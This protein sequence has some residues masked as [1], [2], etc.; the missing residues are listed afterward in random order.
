VKSADASGNL[1]VSGE[2]SFTTSAQPSYAVRVNA[3]GNEYHGSGKDWSADQE[4]TP[5]SWGYVGGRIHKTKHAIANT[6]DDVLYKSERYRMKAYRFTVPQNGTYQVT[7]LFAEIYYTATGKRVFDVKIEGQRVIDDL[8]IYAEVGHD[9][10]FSR[11]F[12]VNVNDGVLDIEFV[13]NI[14]SPKIS[15]IEVVAKTL[16]KSKIGQEIPDRQNEIVAEQTLPVDFQLTSPFPNPFNMET[17]I[18]LDIPETGYLFAAIYNIRGQKVITISDEQVL[19]GQK[20]M[21]WN[22]RDEYGYEMSSGI[23]LLKVVYLGENNQ[24][25]SQTK[26]L[27]L[28][29]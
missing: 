8:D 17:K 9:Y 23:Y 26:R 11:T 19:P 15:A 29:K 12:Q 2:Q 10:A 20:E 14:D 24:K 6:V 21:I 28:M 13:K 25:I 27:I 16:G 4:Y 1:A 5:G 3:G 7:L 18:R 22:G